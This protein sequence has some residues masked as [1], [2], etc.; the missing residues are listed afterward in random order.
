MSLARSAEWY[1]I[2]C[3]REEIYPLN[4]RVWKKIEMIEAGYAKI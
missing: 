3:V 2:R 4:L 1:S